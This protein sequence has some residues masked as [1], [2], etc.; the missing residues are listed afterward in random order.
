MPSNRNKHSPN[1]FGNYRSTHETVI[2]QF[3]NRGFILSEDLNFVA[4]DGFILLEGTIHCAG[5]IH[6]TVEKRMKVLNGDGENAMVERVAYSYNVSLS[7]RGNIFRYDSP[8]STHNKQN[9]LHRFDV[10]NNDHD[11]TIS[12]IEDEDATPTLGEVISEAEEW[13]YQHS[14]EVHR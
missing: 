1:R 7:Q 5:H 8:H 2:E 9:H 11:G 13:Y 14:G 6:I 4:I 12:F 10:L 3:K